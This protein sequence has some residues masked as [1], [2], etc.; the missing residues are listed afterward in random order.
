MDEEIKKA[1]EAK[2]KESQDNLA[3]LQKEGEATKAELLKAHAKIE[4]QGIAL[5]DFMEAQK[6][7][8]IETVLGQYKNFLT[9]NYDEIEAIRQKGPGAGG[10]TFV[11]KAASDMSTASGGN[12]ETA[13]TNM[14]T[15]LGNFNLRNDNSLLNLCSVTSTNMD[16]FPYT[17]TLPEDET[18]DF[19]AEGGSKPKISF[20][21][22]NRY[23]APRKIAAHEVLSSEVAQ[24]IQNMVDVARTYLRT[25]H[26]LFK[27][28]AVFFGDGTGIKPIG[29]T[30]YG[31]TFVAGDM[32]LKITKPNFMDTVNACIT[33]IYTTQNFVDEMPYKANIVMI[34]PIDFFV[35]FQSAK[36]ENGLPLYPQASLFNQVSIGGV[37]IIP[38]S[39]IPSGKIFVA[40]MSK[41]NVV[42][43]IPFQITV[44][45]I[46]DQFI[47]NQFT[48]VGE[49]R[50]YSY[51]KNLDQQAFIYD[52]IATVKLAITKA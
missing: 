52:D 20:K 8:K 22:E 31:R 41:Y 17:E 33:D 2:F 19:V 24:D 1:L 27:V 51:V 40:D 46:N 3:K 43:Y 44:G 25:K 48:M 34:N 13:P 39:K 37:T 35:E 36:D 32:A 15:S 49:S 29:A 10:M 18:Y 50:F 30:V 45:W 4:K 23:Q 16:S 42:N 47:T 6:E 26:D 7:K 9:E 14:N 12:V 28:D 5:Q 38:W 21:W 11:P